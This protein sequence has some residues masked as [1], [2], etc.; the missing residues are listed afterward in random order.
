MTILRD[1]QQHS[2]DEIRGAFQAHRRVLLVSPTG[3]GKTVMFAYIAAGIYQKGKRALIL[4]HRRELLTQISGAL[5]QFK[6]PHG[7]L[8]ADSRGIPRMPVTVASVFTLVRRLHHFPPPDLIV[9]DEAHHFTVKSSWGKCVQAFPRAR[10][11]GVTATP[12]RLDGQGLSD[13][14]EYM[15][16]GPSVAELTLQGWLSPAEVYAPA[17]LPDLKGIRK[18]AGDYALNELEAAIDKPVITG[19]AVAHYAK[20][21]PGKRAVAFCC[22]VKHSQHVA[23][24][25]RTVG[26]RAASVDGSM[27]D[28]ERDRII[29]AFGRGDIDVLTSCDLISEGFDL[30]AIEVAI[31]LR[32][33]QSLALYMQQVGRAIRP[34]P[35]KE[36]TI[37]LD[38]AGN[39]MRHGFIDEPRDW[40][41]EGRAPEKQ[42]RESVAR[43]A[44]CPKCFAMHRPAPCC[45]KCGHAYEV[46]GRVVEQVDGELVRMVDGQQVADD[47]EAMR[48]E[49]QRQ[50][51]ILC[52]IAR[53]RNY[54]NPEGWAFH[55]LAA[56]VARK[57]PAG[58]GT[59]T[60]NGLTEAE[61]NRLWQE[62]TAA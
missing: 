14:F 55:V 46:K 26:Y 10:V 54:E 31:L 34:S 53:K 44:T 48:R 5:K 43:V 41:L 36:R 57:S 40:T 39:T 24:E 27:E 20:I 61:R 51:R 2:I 25:F 22:S 19:S 13:C 17:R 42:E 1:Y 23:E 52:A 45:P 37:V 58:D 50:F 49:N 29:R 18:R 28:R 38:H 62:V 35:G 21:A 60:I 32:P 12:C 6:I 7:I 3:S 16:M 59:T 56:K 30:P 15:V 47:A 33:T 11:L 4:A 9:G 8:S